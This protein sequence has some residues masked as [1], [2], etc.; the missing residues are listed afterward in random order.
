MEI[1]FHFQKR[2]H[3]QNRRNLKS[4]IGSI[5]ER[6]KK[7][8]ESVSFVFC[9]DPFI[10]Q[11]N[12]DHL[13]HDYYTDV[14]TFNLSEKGQPITG[15]IYISIDTVKSNAVLFKS[16]LKNEL[17]RVIF[18]SVLHLCGYDDKTEEYKT[19]MTKME[20]FYLHLYSAK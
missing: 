18:H 9:D 10:L 15:E 3:L 5:F 2:V 14:I 8:A 6:E 20:D 4:F 16:S 12:R 13:D 1:T 11:I 7:I 19:L 17:L